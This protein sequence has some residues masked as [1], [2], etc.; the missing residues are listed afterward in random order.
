[1]THVLTPVPL[2]QV[3]EGGFVMPTGLRPLAQE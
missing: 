3:G 2:P 1:M